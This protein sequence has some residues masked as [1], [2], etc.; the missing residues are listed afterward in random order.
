MVQQNA[1]SV[2]LLGQDSVFTT[3]IPTYQPTIDPRQYAPSTNYIP[4]AKAVNIVNSDYDIEKNNAPLFLGLGNQIRQDFLAQEP[5][6][7]LGTSVPNGY[8]DP[9]WGFGLR[10]DAG[11]LVQ[12][13][14]TSGLPSKEDIPSDHGYVSMIRTIV[15]GQKRYTGDTKSLDAAPHITR[16]TYVTKYVPSKLQARGAII[17]LAPMR[18]ITGPVSGSGS[19]PIVQPILN[20]FRPRNCYLAENIPIYTWNRSTNSSN[21]FYP[22]GSSTTTAFACVSATDFDLEAPGFAGRM[23]LPFYN[24]N[25]GFSNLNTF[26]DA[27]GNPILSTFYN[28]EYLYPYAGYDGVVNGSLA[29]LGGLSTTATVQT[30]RSLQAT[31][32]GINPNAAID[33]A[34]TGTT[35]NY[36]TYLE[37]LS[38]ST[39]VFGQMLVD[40]NDINSGYTNYLRVEICLSGYFSADDP[41]PGYQVPTQR[42]T[43]P[44]S[45]RRATMAP[46]PTCTTAKFIF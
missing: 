36:E 45:E 46:G 32:G 22:F 1:N 43:N 10:I 26:Y 33:S 19:G 15:D 9:V 21:G 30:L 39:L 7:G 14:R 44:W 37:G 40:L 29:L 24:V 18:K 42:A 28:D 13:P 6:D 8:G 5:S 16:L 12:Y 23:P 27:L 31:S 17:P 34:F 38:P 41:W 4:S 25:T 3:S 2:C 20:P 35:A 11:A